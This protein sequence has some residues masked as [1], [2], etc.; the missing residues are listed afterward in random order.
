MTIHS[1]IFLHYGL[2]RH[3]IVG[4]CMDLSER[5]L[6]SCVVLFW[7]IDQSYN[8]IIRHNYFA[9]WYTSMFSW[10]WR[11]CEVCPLQTFSVVIKQNVCTN[12][13][14]CPPALVTSRAM[15]HAFLKTSKQSN[16]NG[17]IIASLTVFPS[18]TL[19]AS[20]NEIENNHFYYPVSR[21]L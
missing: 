10:V 13:D 15:N 9:T 16:L 17:I 2:T 11:D 4:K 18:C 21:H 19:W 12:G 14:P 7:Y 1:H 20:Y 5:S 3:S 8:Y 6:F